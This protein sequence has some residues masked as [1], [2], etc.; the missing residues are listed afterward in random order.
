MRISKPNDIDFLRIIESRN[1]LLASLKEMM[2]WS[3]RFVPEYDKE[4]Y[5]AA[6]ERAKVAIEC[7]S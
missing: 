2:Q 1:E 6:K 4:K 3:G 5:F 7:A